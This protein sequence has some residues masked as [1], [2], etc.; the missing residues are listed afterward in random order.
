VEDLQDDLADMFEDMAEINDLMARSY[1]TPDGLDEVRCLSSYLVRCSL[2]LLPG[3]LGYRARSHTFST[4]VL[5]AC[6][7][8]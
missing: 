4:C 7:C 2:R 8:G 5:C 3:R 1:A 6:Q